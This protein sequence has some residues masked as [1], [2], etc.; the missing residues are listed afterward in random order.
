MDN[1]SIFIAILAIVLVTAAVY[2][3]GGLLDNAPNDLELDP[4]IVNES[5]LVTFGDL[6]AGA[7]LA[8][9]PLKGVDELSYGLVDF[10]LQ[11]KKEESLL[12][13]VASTAGE[14]LVGDADVIVFDGVQRTGASVS[15]LA[16]S[17][18][19][20]DVADTLLGTFLFRSLDGDILP[21]FTILV[22][23]L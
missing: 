18:D 17:N 13:D 9:S 15:F 5:G 11:H 20:Q 16:I 1:Q 21:G 14:K 23:T 4:F 2:F 6:P 12:R 8:L 7:Q 10:T 19:F 22:P 3:G